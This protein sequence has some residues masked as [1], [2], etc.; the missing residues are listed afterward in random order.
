MSKLANLAARRRIGAGLIVSAFVPMLAQADFA[1]LSGEAAVNGSTLGHVMQPQVAVGPQGDSIVVFQGGAQFGPDIYIRRYDAAGNARAA[2][3]VVNT[4]TGGGQRSPD[5]ARSSNGASIVVWEGPSSDG[6]GLDI[7][8]QRYDASGARLGSEQRVN[9]YTSG[10]QRQ[11]KVAMDGSGG[12]VVTFLGQGHQGVPY[13]GAVHARHFNANGA[14][15]SDDFLGCTNVAFTTVDHDIAMDAKGNFAVVCADGSHNATS[16]ILDMMLFAAKAKAGTAGVRIGNG[17]QPAIAMA[18]NGTMVLTWTGHA[19]GENPTLADTGIGARRDSAAGAPLGS[20]VRVNAYD[21]DAQFEPDVAIDAKGDHL[22]S[23]STPWQ[24]GDGASVCA[25]RYSHGGFA[26]G[27]EFRINQTTAGDQMGSVV[28]LDADGDVVAFWEDLPATGLA[29]ARIMARRYRGD[30][31]VNLSATL[32][33]NRSSATAGQTVTFTA[34]LSNVMSP[35]SPTG[36]VGTPMLDRPGVCTPSGTSY[37]CTLSTPLL[38]GQVARATYAV[39]PNGGGN[40][41]SSATSGTDSHDQHA[42]NNTQS[43]TI[44]VLR[45]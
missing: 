25:Q 34:T 15:L 36:V 33:A 42:P 40:L 37:V 2:A 13:P 41:V 8:A 20:N 31:M 21:Y 43:L 4:V 30:A 35:Q 29:Q 12:Y 38:A 1:S 39:N 45:P 23:W 9:K 7:W 24:D 11:P 17:A 14:P 28:G 18:P 32:S 3:S 44:G 19:D 27:G 16:G 6:Q 26:K 5:V 22:I 10:D